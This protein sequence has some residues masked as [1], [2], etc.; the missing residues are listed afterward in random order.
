MQLFIVFMDKT[1][2]YARLVT[3]ISTKR[4]E[5]VAPDSSAALAI[6]REKN[7]D[8]EVSMYWP[9]FPQPRAIRS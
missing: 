5:I 6:A 1:L 4:M 8:R 3:R 7:P 9:A 2:R